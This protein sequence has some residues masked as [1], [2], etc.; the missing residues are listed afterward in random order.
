LGK[1]KNTKVQKI[2]ND[3]TKE[4]VKRWKGKKIKERKEDRKKGRKKE[5][6]R[7]LRCRSST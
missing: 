2:K 6:N 3:R 1:R 4:R 7:W 5:R